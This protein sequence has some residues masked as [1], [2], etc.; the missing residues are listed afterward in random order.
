MKTTLLLPNR[1]KTIGWFILIPSAIAGLAALITHFD[2][3]EFKVPVFA[4]ISDDIFKPTS[5]FSIVHAPIVYTILGL[6][7]I[8]GAL[9]VGFSKE[10][11]EDEFIANL[12]L[13]SLQWAVLVNYILLFLAFAFVYGVAFFSVMMYSIFTVLLIFIVRFNYVLYKNAKSAPDEK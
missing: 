11:T 10:K 4:I 9:L 13:S 3:Q 7:I 5:Y 2:G 12:R 8:A 6:L 1:F